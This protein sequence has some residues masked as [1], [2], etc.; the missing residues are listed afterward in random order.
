M[1]VLQAK[2]AYEVLVFLSRKQLCEAVSRYLSSRLLLNSDPSRIHLLA[3]PYLMN[4]NV[5]KL[6]L[7]SISVALYQAYSLSVVTPESLLSVK[8]EANIAVEAILVLRFH[9]SS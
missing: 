3:E 7:D 8:R 1:N 9:A 4:I 5:A 2:L 6:S